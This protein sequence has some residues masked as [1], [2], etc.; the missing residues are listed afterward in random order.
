M[1]K[2][3][4]YTRE[5][6]DKD[7]RIV[8][9]VEHRGID[10]DNCYEDVDLKRDLIKHVVG[11]KNLRVG[12]NRENIP[13][14]PIDDCEASRI[15]KAAFNYYNTALK[16]M[17]EYGRGER[18]L[19]DV[20]PTRD[21]TSRLP[22]MVSANTSNTEQLVLNLGMSGYANEELYTGTRRR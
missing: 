5:E 11:K 6:Y 8:D 12:S 13:F 16:R 2:K 3:A 19:M 22:V 7:R 18:V 14:V 9:F 17:G 4:D 20:Q 1:A 15:H 21:L 10:F